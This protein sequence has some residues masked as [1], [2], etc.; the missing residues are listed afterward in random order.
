MSSRHLTLRVCL[1]CRQRYPRSFEH[2]RF[3]RVRYD[4]SSRTFSVDLAAPEPGVA[5]DAKAGKGTLRQQTVVVDQLLVAAG[6]RPATRDLQCERAGIKLDSE[7]LVAV[8]DA[9]RTSARNVWAFGDVTGRNLFRHAANFEGEYLLETVVYPLHEA[10]QRSA[11][12]QSQS[13]AS[14]QSSTQQQGSEAAAPSYEWSAFPTLTGLDGR[15]VSEP[16]SENAGFSPAAQPALDFGGG[17]QARGEAV[18]ACS[19][20][21]LCIKIRLRDL[22]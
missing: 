17:P 8:D 15:A 6:V 19:G 22:P 10:K 21:V 14:G 13:Q 7:G 4:A 12:S 1:Q 16:R 20:H 3:D 2:V 9:L 11:Q 18:A 5:G